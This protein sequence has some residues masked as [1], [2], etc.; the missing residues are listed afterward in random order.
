MK[1][2]ANMSKYIVW[3]QPKNT[4]NPSAIHHT[5]LTKPGRIKEIFSNFFKQVGV[6][7]RE[8][9][10]K[11]EKN[12]AGQ[13]N[14]KYFVKKRWLEAADSLARLNG[15]YIKGKKGVWKSATDEPPQKR[16]VI[17]YQPLSTEQLENV[18]NR[19]C[20]GGGGAA[21]TQECMACFLHNLGYETPDMDTRAF[22]FKTLFQK[23]GHVR[24][25]LAEVALNSGLMNKC[26]DLLDMQCYPWL[27][28]PSYL[29]KI[30]GKLT[31]MNDTKRNIANCRAAIKVV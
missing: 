15:H 2:D 10:G 5:K 31:G 26:Y 21:F 18:V 9:D 29:N 6:N 20:G 19:I 27:E 30:C 4:N 23:M 7:R 17:D 8:Y 25:A 3:V 22:M 16:D 24:N 1:K 11:M 14:R 13:K 28:S 12:E